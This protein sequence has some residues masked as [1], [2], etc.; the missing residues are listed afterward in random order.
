MPFCKNKN[1]C[2]PERSRRAKLKIIK[3]DKQRYIQK[4]PSSANAT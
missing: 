3:N 2:H 4:T 1:Y